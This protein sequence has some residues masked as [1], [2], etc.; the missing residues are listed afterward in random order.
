M[1]SQPVPSSS[2][3]ALPGPATVHPA[4]FMGNPN[5]DRAAPPR[6]KKRAKKKPVTRKKR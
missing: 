5:V 6:K 1:F 4:W 3:S 2:E